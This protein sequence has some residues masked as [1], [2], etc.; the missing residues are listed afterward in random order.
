MKQINTWIE[1]H[2][3]T[4]LFFYLLLQPFLDITAGIFTLFDFP[5]LIGITIRLLFFLFC[6]YY[7]IFISNYKLSKYYTITTYLY[8]L[9]F[10]IYTVIV[11]DF[12]VIFYELQNTFNAFY[13]PIIFLGLV[14]MIPR[15]HIQYKLKH[16][17]ILFSIYIF[18]VFFPTITHTN[19][20]S[21]E[22]SKVGSAGWFYST[23]SVS[24]IISVLLPFLCIYIKE[25]KKKL[26]L[27]L[28]ILGILLYSIFTLGT[29]VPILSIGIIL[30]FNIL[31]LLIYLWKQK[32]Y[33]Y[34]V[35]STLILITI[36]FGS[37]LIIP[38]TSFYK[39]IEI[40]MEF[41]EIDS[42]IDALKD[43][44]LL[45]HFIFSQRLTFFKNT[46]LS[47]QQTNMIGKIIGIGYIE[48]YGTDSVNLK[49]IEMDYFDIFYRHGILGFIIYFFPFF[50]FV[51]YKKKHVYNS[52]TKLN[53]H[54]SILLIFILA[55]F[56]GHIF[57][58]P[59][60][61]IIVTM[62]FMIEN[63]ALESKQKQLS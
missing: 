17:I 55:F 15:Y 61:S 6:T 31:Y 32:K 56:S 45:D 22:I 43:P 49:T 24:A 3:K 63:G 54:I 37:L 27:W 13:F 51:K 23:N 40:H 16:I 50:I 11:K 18:F 33:M 7:L 26:Y 25:N 42:P 2:I 36:T 48:N 1:A 30:F 8:L 60:T 19:L 35:T 12:S 46:A 4:I 21:Y 34:I 44:Y 39:N 41:L 5:N 47:W 38:K 52:Y 9:L 10:T 58:A 62:I 29:K 53:I 20:N 28:P 57:V 59:A 14:E